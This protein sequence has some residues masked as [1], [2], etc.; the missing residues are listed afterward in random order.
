[1]FTLLIIFFSILLIFLLNFF[2]LRNN[3]LLDKKKLLHKSFI[4]KDFVPLTGG[5]V[6]IFNFLIFFFDVKYKN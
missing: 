4:S 6:I 2:F 1:M 5:F 3:F